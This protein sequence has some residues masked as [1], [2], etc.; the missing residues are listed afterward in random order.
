MKVSVIIPVLN[1]E[2]KLPILLTSLNKQTVMPDEI[3]IVDG[4]S[5]DTT[6]VSSAQF[7]LQYIYSQ[8]GISLQRNTGALQSKGNILCFL[9]ADTI[10]SKNFIKNIKKSYKSGQQKTI[11]P[12]YLPISK[13][14]FLYMFFVGLNIYFFLCQ[15][16][17]PAVGGPCII[18]TSDIFKKVGGFKQSYLFEDIYFANQARRYGKVKLSPVLYIKTSDRRFK[19]EGYIKTSFTYIKIALFSLFGK[20]NLTNKIKYSFDDHEK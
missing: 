20:Y 15:F 6:K 14:P 7:K 9:D 2:K 10:V 19:R 8:K 16:L 4:G 5:T 18:T 12:W 13:N 11:F 3:I 17:R 1:E